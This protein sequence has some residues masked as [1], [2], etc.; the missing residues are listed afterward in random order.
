VGIS[1]AEDAQS[2]RQALAVAFQY[3]SKVVVEECIRGR[4]VEC[5]VLGNDNPQASIPGEIVTGGGHAFY[6]YEAKYID[7]NGA[8]LLIPA[9]LD[10]RVTE[11]VRALA[12][13][14]FTVLCCD[15]MA[16]VDMF[17]KESG[18]VLVNEINTIP[19]FTRISMYP[20]LWEASGLPCAK[21]IDRLVE[22]AIKRHR[23]KAR[24][25]YSFGG[26]KRRVS[27]RAKA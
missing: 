25:R 17:V 22:L 15:G 16:R 12:L 6:D 21:L 18:E 1:R 26:A 10:A 2:F 19:G 14:A 4:E 3:D 8:R 20:Q 5:A 9:P 27:R 11:T 23:E 7:E 24:T 13:R